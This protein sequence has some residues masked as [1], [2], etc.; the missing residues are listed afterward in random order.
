MAKTV[1]RKRKPRYG[2]IFF[3]VALMVLF[4]YAVISL[5]IDLFYKEQATYLVSVGNLNIE[6]EYQALVLRN[7]LIVDTNLSGKIAYFANEGEVIEKNHQIAEIFNDGSEV[8]MAAVDERE[9]NR[10]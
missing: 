10:K 2:R 8:V 5:G 3:S 6:N 1:K 9:L 4:L 7:E